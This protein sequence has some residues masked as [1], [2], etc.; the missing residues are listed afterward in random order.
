V[1]GFISPLAGIKGKKNNMQSFRQRRSAPEKQPQ[2]IS[3]PVEE[4]TDETLIRALALGVMWGLDVLYERYSRLLYSVAY[5]MVA[6][7]QIA[8][9]LLQETF[10]ALWQNASSYSSQ[11][12]AVRNWLVA[13]I[14]HRAIDYL[15][16]LRTHQDFKTTPIDD[17]IYNDDLTTPD[18]WDEVWK[19]VQGAQVRNALKTLSKEQRMVI[20]LGYFQGWTQT[21]IAEKYQIPLGTVKARMRL[22]LMRLRRVLDQAGGGHSSAFD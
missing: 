22:A 21:E 5:R 11:A 15:R 18:V 2:N 10:V 1:A 7:H 20:E 17:L 8:E 4:L 14:R 6:D 9:D 3:M 19:S 16:K 12:G 13:I